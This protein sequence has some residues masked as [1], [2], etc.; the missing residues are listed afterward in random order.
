MSLRKAA[1]VVAITAL[2]ALLSP[3]S[4]QAAPKS[5]S[6]TTCHLPESDAEA[7]VILSNYYPGYWWDHTDLTVYVQAH[8]SATTAQRQA[9]NGAIET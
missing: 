8:P 4:A 6:G 5:A 9:I 7:L 2:A 3:L 1:L